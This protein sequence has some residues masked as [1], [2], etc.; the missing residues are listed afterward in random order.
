MLLCEGMQQLNVGVSIYDDNLRLVICNPTFR[1]IF[2]LPEAMTQPGAPLGPVLYLLA[3]RGAYGHVNPDRFVHDALTSLRTADDQPLIFERCI[4]DG[5]VFES[6]TSRLASGGYITIHADITHHKD[7]QVRLLENQQRLSEKTSEL[8]LILE[9]AS[10]GIL[11]VVPTNDGR[12]I[13]RRVNRTLERLLGYGEAELEGRATRMLYPNDHEY[14][15]V[16][17]GYTEIVCFGG[18]YHAEHVFAK[19]DGSTMLGILRGSAIDPEDPTRGAIWMIED[20]TER[21][22]IETEL[23]A[24]TA[25]LET[26]T[27]NMAGAMVIWDND[28]RYLW[29]TPRT[30]DYFN[31]PHGTL[32]VGLP[33]LTMARYFAER[34]DFGPG[35]VDA[36]IAMQMH[37]FYTRQPMRLERNMPDGTVLEVRRNPLPNGGFVSVFLDITERKQ[38]EVELLEAKEAAEAALRTL[39]RKQE[40]VAILLNSSGQGFLSFGASLRIDPEFSQACQTM[41]GPSPAGKNVLDLLCPDDLAL[42]EQCRESMSTAFS[43]GGAEGAAAVMA[44]PQQFQRGDRYLQANFRMLNNGHMMAVLTDITNEKRLQNLST[45]DR[46][47]GMANRRKLDEDLELEHARAG[48]TGLSFSVIMVDID[49]FKDVN[50]GYG[51]LV[52]DQILAETA[53]IL[54]GGVRLVDRIG[55]WGGEEF[56]IICPNT[57]VS[58]GEELAEKLRQAVQHHRFAGPGRITASFGVAEFRKEETI[59][60]LVR[61][62]DEGLYR[63]KQGGRNRVVAVLL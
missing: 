63:A 1:D 57:I 29:W 41:L 44:L 54:Q 49:R 7:A 4:A 48:R 14:N 10:L 28:L 47:T 36:Q 27:D 25:L 6:H 8:E 52:G 42:R 32:K 51:H 2:E 61:R 59:E 53:A 40:Q 31:L 62:A 46:L 43:D 11:T 24:K 20:I 18:T 60:S 9:N 35:D 58:G 22:R 39:R 16:S 33:M 38:M 19:K 55:R 12:R 23:A 50:D 26:G 21:K 3:M 17:T 15:L 34:G 56:M 30:E 37:P 45:T 13:M 5:R